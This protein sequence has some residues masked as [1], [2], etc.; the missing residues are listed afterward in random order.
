MPGPILKLLPDT[1]PGVSPLRD[2]DDLSSAL[3]SVIQGEQ[4]VWSRWLTARSRC[5]GPR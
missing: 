5:A 1:E 4:T 3:S 2:P